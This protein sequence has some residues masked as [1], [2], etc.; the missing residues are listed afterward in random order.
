MIITPG[1]LLVSDLSGRLGLGGF[2]TKFSSKRSININEQ[3][4]SPLPV[5]D[6]YYEQVLSP[7][8]PPRSSTLI[9]PLKML[10]LAHGFCPA[11]SGTS[12]LIKP[13]KVNS[14]AVLK[15]RD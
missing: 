8:P 7:L 4:L 9:V 1:A 10:L 13:S 3:V 12:V 11:V 5:S 6:Q 2:C 14:A 15:N